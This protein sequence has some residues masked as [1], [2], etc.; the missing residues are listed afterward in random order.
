MAILS[1]VV[2]HSFASTRGLSSLLFRIISDISKNPRVKTPGDAVI[3]LNYHTMLI[4]FH[5]SIIE[6]HRPLGME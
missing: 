2:S 3:T 1:T 6:K 5:K 4:C